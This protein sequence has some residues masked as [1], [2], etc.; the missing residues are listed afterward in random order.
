MHHGPAPSTRRAS[1]RCRAHDPLGPS[2]Q[3]GSPNR[4]GEGSALREATPGKIQQWIWKLQDEALR[5]GP[6]TVLQLPK[7]RSHGWTCWEESQ[8]CRYCAGNQSSSQCKGNEWVT[9]KCV[10]CGESHAITIRVCPR[11]VAAIK[12][13]KTAQVVDWTKSSSASTMNV[14]SKKFVFIMEDFQRP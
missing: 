13:S 7:V 10:N 1:P 11:M 8:T 2:S 12:K 4:Y 5:K 3:T 9:L 14:W 6:T